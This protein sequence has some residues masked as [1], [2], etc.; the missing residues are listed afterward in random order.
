MLLNVDKG[1][2]FIAHE[3]NLKHIFLIKCI[4]HISLLRECTKLHEMKNFKY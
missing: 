4:V 1:V 3:I 2:L